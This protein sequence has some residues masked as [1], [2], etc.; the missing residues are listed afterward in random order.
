MGQHLGRRD[1][2]RVAESAM[3]FVDIRG[4]NYIV[5]LFFRVGGNIV[6]CDELLGH[7]KKRLLRM[8]LPSLVVHQL[9]HL[10]CLDHALV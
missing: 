8:A 3:W 4:Q 2:G 1:L 6:L 10:A 5:Y 7:D 9:N